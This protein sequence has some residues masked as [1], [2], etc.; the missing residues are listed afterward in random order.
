VDGHPV[1]KRSASKVT[2]G[3]AKNALRRHD[4]GGTAVEEVVFLRGH[5]PGLGPYDR[6][7]T[8]PLLREGQPAGCPATLNESREHV[9]SVLATLPPDAFCLSP[10]TP[11]IRTV[12]T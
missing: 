1:A 8:V 7:L 5:Q 12:F 10:G 9:A 2:R 4:A 11:A 3:G 6:L